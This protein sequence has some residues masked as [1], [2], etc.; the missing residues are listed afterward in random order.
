MQQKIERV[1]KSNYEYY[2]E[3]I[4]KVFKV[5]LV[6]AVENFAKI[7]GNALE[8]LDDEFFA[9]FVHDLH[10]RNL[11]IQVND[12]KSFQSYILH[13]YYFCKEKQLFRFQSDI[14]QKLIDTDIKKVDGYF[15]RLPAESIYLHFPYNTTVKMN[16]IRGGVMSVSGVYVFMRNISEDLTMSEKTY[17]AKDNARLVKLLILSGN[18][19]NF[20]KQSQFFCNFVIEEGKDIFQTIKYHINKFIIS[21]QE[22]AIPYVEEVFKFVCNS[23][24]YINSANADINPVKAKYNTKARTPLEKAQDAPFSKINFKSVGDTI[25]IDRSYDNSLSNKTGRKNEVK[26]LHWLVRPH[27]R[28]QVVG[29]GRLERKLIWIEKFVKGKDINTELVKKEYNVK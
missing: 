25:T 14:T 3:Y 8:D 1:I 7:N 12:M 4:K 5:D 2:T 28:Q 11:I 21:G 15:L 26:T 18:P 27:W 6:E 10:I 19:I 20:E 9:E 16:N 13:T 23:I 17:T 24:L 29:K 22:D